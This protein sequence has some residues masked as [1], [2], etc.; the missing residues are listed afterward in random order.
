MKRPVYAYYTCKT[1]NP[2]SMVQQI[3]RCRNIKY[4]KFLF[5]SKKF[6]NNDDTFEEHTE[7]FESTNKYANLEFKA[8]TDE[9]TY[10]KFFK[11]ISYYEFNQKSYNTNKFS[12]FLNLI[13]SRGFVRDK[14]IKQKTI[15]KS[16]RVIKDSIKEDKYENFNL[17][18]YS[19]VN[20]ILRMTEEQAEN[21]KD[22]FIDKYKLTKHFNLCN[23]VNQN[24]EKIKETLLNKLDFN[25]VKIKSDKSK[26]VFLKRLKKEFKNEEIEIDSK[27][28][29][30]D[31]SKKINLEYNHYFDKLTKIPDYTDKYECDKLQ[32]RI[33][34]SL[35]PDSM[36]IS[37]KSNKRGETRD[38]M[39][40]TIDQETIEEHLSIY[41][42][43][44]PNQ[45]INFIDC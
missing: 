31:V 27:P 40:Y 39:T 12:H 25:I 24:E 17:E 29:S 2:K 30:K 11:L 4:L 6:F 15:S 44:N 8:L 34:K 19:K 36:V 28:V 16:N 45:N 9:K 13:D 41:R 26:L 33:Y 10:E 23:Y 38:K 1:I 7:Q 14:T 21:N 32:A 18:D 43:R 20:D 35:F 42:I 37:K 22:L 3:A 5:T